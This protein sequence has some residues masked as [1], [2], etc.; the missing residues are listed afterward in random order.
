M[1]SKICSGNASSVLRV[2]SN[3]QQTIDKIK[4]QFDLLASLVNIKSSLIEPTFITIAKYNKDMGDWMIRRFLSSKNFEKHAPLTANLV[5]CDRGEAPNRLQM[6][7]DYLMTALEEDGGS[8]G[9]A[10]R[11]LPATQVFVQTVRLCAPSL[12]G[13]KRIDLAVPTTILMQ[14]IDLAATTNSFTTDQETRLLR[15]FVVLL[16]CPPAPFVNSL[17]DPVG[18]TKALLEAEDVDALKTKQRQILVS[19]L[20]ASRS[21]IAEKVHQ[22]ELLLNE[23]SLLLEELTAPVPPS[24]PAEKRAALEHA[25]AFWAS[26]S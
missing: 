12:V 2:I 18:F 6:L 11:L 1:L 21:E 14:V 20:A 19:G 26:V 15:Q 25:L 22:Q 24:E 8:P 5:M 4:S 16:L 7:Q 23:L 3:Q 13:H 17:A 10:A 9:L